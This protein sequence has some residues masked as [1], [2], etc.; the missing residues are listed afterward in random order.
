MRGIICQ[1]F[2]DQCSLGEHLTQ[3]TVNHSRGRPVTSRNP[4]NGSPGR[5]ITR[6]IQS[7]ACPARRMT[8]SD[9]SPCTSRHRRRHRNAALCGRGKPMTR[10]CVVLSTVRPRDPLMGKVLG[11]G[12]LGLVQLLDRDRPRDRPHRRCDLGAVH[13]RGPCIRRRRPADRRPDQ[14]PRRVAIGE[15]LSVQ[16]FEQPGQATR[17]P[18]DDPLAVP[19]T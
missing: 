9:R 11:I 4:V 18:E 15:R 5:P 2:A 10:R 3:T 16:G 8:S 14:D 17:V 13:D 12:T 1:G 19:R 7:T 6:R